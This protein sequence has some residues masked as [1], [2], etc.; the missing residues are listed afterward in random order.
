MT[1]CKREQPNAPK[2]GLPGSRNENAP[3]LREYQP[4]VLPERTEET[5][6]NA[7]EYMGQVKE[8]LA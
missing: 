7:R 2:N 5:A 8:L 3:M 1:W 4:P 6:A